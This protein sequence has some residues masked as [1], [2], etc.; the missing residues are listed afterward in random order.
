MWLRE[1]LNTRSF[2]GTSDDHPPLHYPS[3][4]VYRL[5]CH[6][7]SHPPYS[8]PLPPSPNHPLNVSHLSGYQDERKTERFLHSPP[9]TSSQRLNLSLTNLKIPITP[10]LCSSPSALPLLPFPLFFALCPITSHSTP[11][12]HPSTFSPFSVL[13]P[14]TKLHSPNPHLRSLPTP[15]LF[16]LS[17]FVTPL[18]D[19]SNPSLPLPHLL[20]GRS[21]HPL[22]A[23]HPKTHISLF[24]TVHPGS[25]NQRHLPVPA[26]VEL[27]KMNAQNRTLMLRG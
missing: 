25:K 26:P 9:T 2:I 1:H 19:K 17:S 22:R 14:N 23:P 5:R 11:L 16:F 24:R 7:H 27:P 20:P 8:V 18:L 4:Q 6:Y 13:P 21:F 15:P 12:K 3:N 10:P